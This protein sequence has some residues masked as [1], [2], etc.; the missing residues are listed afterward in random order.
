M[1]KK[2]KVGERL[3]RLR[4]KR[5]LSQRDLSEP[6][7]SYAY[8]SRI[9]AGARTP[10]VKALRKVAP[11]LGVSVRYLEHGDEGPI[12]EGL[13][14]A[15]VTLADLTDDELHLIQRVSEAHARAGA[16][17][18]ALRVLDLREQ[19]RLEQ[20]EAEAEEIRRRQQLK[21]GTNG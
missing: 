15:G 6:G 10:S 21:G 13:A 16:H 8:I 19:A 1:S 3:K 9:E 4:L 17:E 18:A 14:I 11:K 2:E 12:E 5:G 7:V 20:I